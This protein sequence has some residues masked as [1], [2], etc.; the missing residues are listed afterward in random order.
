MQLSHTYDKYEHDQTI[1]DC[2]RQLWR[3]SADLMFIM[4]VEEGGEFALYDNNPASKKVMGLEQE[5]IVHRLNLREQFGDEMAEQVYDTYHEVISAGKPISVE[6]NGVRGDGSKIYFDTLFVPIYD[7]LGDPIFVCGVS[8]DI[9]KIKDA[10]KVALQANEKLTEYSLALESVNHDLDRKVRERTAEFERA[11]LIA[12]EALEAK[13]SFVAR[14]SHEIRTPIN[15]VI[16]LSYLCLKTPLNEEQT[17]SVS[18]ILSAGESLLSIVNDVLDFSK[19]EAGKMTLEESP[20]HIAS[21]LEHAINLNVVQAEAKQI[22]LRSDVSPYIPSSLLGDPL[23]IQQLLVNLITNAVKFTER[24]GITVRLSSSPISEQEILLTGEVIDTGIGISIKDQAR[25]FQSFQQADDSDTRVFGGTG[26]GLA[27]CQQICQLMNG[28]IKV[29]SDLGKGATFRFNIPL[30]IYQETSEK[31]KSSAKVN[32]AI[33]NCQACKI[34]LVEDNLINQKVMLGYLNETNARVI[35]ANNGQEALDKVLNEDFDLI[36]MDI[37]MPVMDGLTATQKLRALD[38]SKNIPIFAMTA[39][40][41]DDAKRKSAQAGMNGHLDKPIDKSELYKILQIQSQKILQGNSLVCGGKL[42]SEAFSY[43][44]EVLSNI[45][46][47]DTLDVWQAIEKLDGKSELYLDL[48]MSF[49]DKYQGFSFNGVSQH[50]TLLIIHSLKSSL[51]YIGAFRLSA[52]CA[53]LEKN[54]V[55]K[56]VSFQQLEKIEFCINELITALNEKLSP[57]F[58]NGELKVTVDHQQIVI[59]K[60]EHIHG[61]LK[62]SDFS[63]EDHLQDAQQMLVGTKYALTIENILYSVSSIEFEYAAVQV[64]ELMFDL[65]GDK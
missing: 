61:L 39:H 4:S 3:Y 54:T 65:Q 27:I 40:V 62:Q 16:G 2:F 17:D 45:S 47:I 9:T 33:P 51:A 21:L 15:A 44:Q 53:E 20:F 28:S 26:L 11:K 60:L 29:E 5:S 34:L 55:T 25:L 22:S 35:I 59:D 19:A 6:Q 52:Y 8:R 58:K 7:A 36:F 14:M 23:K 30:K 48:L 38:V 64:A 18:K 46:A 56:Q 37:Q 43:N 32:V 12:E 57:L 10:E 24:G 31:S 1:L 49:Y 13:S 41:S 50:D 42:I 63:V